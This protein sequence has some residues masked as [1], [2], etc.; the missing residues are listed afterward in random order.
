MLRVPVR[1]AGI[2]FRTGSSGTAASYRSFR[3]LVTALIGLGMTG[4]GVAVL[5]RQQL[6]QTLNVLMGN[7]SIS[8]KTPGTRGHSIRGGH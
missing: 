1:L 6:G 2:H 8:L 7:Q 5:A 4:F 3:L